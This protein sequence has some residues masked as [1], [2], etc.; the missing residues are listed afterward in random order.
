MEITVERDA[1]RFWE[2]SAVPTYILRAGA[3]EVSMELDFTG[4]GETWTDST[5]LTLT[6]DGRLRRADPDG[7]QV[8]YTRCTKSVR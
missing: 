3:R 7:T 4:E 5:T 6:P 8:L 1:L 2:S